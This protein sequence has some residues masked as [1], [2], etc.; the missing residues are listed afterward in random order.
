MLV[1]TRI[2]VQYS[3]RKVVE[4]DRR[5]VAVPDEEAETAS[6]S[7]LFLAIVNHTYDAMEPFTLSIEKQ[8]CPI[9]AQVGKA[10]DS[11]NFQDV[12]LIARLSKV[13][14]AFGMYFKF[15][16]QSELELL[17]SSSVA[18]PRPVRNAFEVGWK[19]ATTT[20]DYMQFACY[21]DIVL[22]SALLMQVLMSSQR[23]LHLPS[24]PSESAVA[25]SKKMALKRDIIKWLE[26]KKVG[27]STDCVTLGA[28]FVDVITDTLWYIDGHHD[29]I[30][31]RACSVPA[32]FN[33]FQGYNRPELTKHRRR[34]A[35]NMCSG[36]LK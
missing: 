29:T 20:R 24:A 4:R 13:V 32:D 22:S 34:L 26:V 11:Q 9:Q 2:V 10:Q 21:H 17:P 5:I 28:R 15:I 7:S 19:V 14:A 3:S 27:W 16:V 31:S 35:E 23:R 8:D 12:P 1:S 36:M 25:R 33:N 6:L 30:R 18:T